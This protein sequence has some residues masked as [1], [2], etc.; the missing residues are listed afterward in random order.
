M[1]HISY[2]LPYTFTQMAF[3]GWANVG[4]TLTHPSVQCWLP[5]LAQRLCPTLA[6]RRQATGKNILLNV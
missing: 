2:K 3:C 1:A 4:P 6:Q 5:T